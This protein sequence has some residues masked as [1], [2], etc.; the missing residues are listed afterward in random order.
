MTDNIIRFIQHGKIRELN[1]QKEQ[2]P[3]TTT[4]LNFLRQSPLH[5]GTKEGCAEGDCGA[6]TVV[7]T[8]TD[9]TGRLSYTAIDSCLVFLPMLHGK[10]LLTIEDL[11]KN[12]AGSDEL[13]PLQQ[14]MVDC[15]GTQ[16][17]YCTPGFAMSLLALQKQPVTPTRTVIEDALT[18]NLCRCTG[19]RS[20][21]DAAAL[22]CTEKK[23]KDDF[24]EQEEL[25]LLQ[26]ATLRQS[27]ADLSIAVGEQRY[28]RPVSLNQALTI[29]KNESDCMVFSGATD[30]ALRVTKRHEKLH[31]LLDL[32]GIDELRTIENDG[33]SVRIGACT[34]LENLRNNLRQ[35]YP[36]LCE[37]LDVFGSR[38]IRS[39]AT[40]GGNIGSASPIGDTLPVLFA[41]DARIELQNTAGKRE[42]PIKE[43]ITG[44]RQTALQPDELITA[45]ILPETNTKEIVRSYKVSKR[46]DLDISTVSGGF[47]LLL[48][49]D[50]VVAITLAFGGM[51]AKTECATSAEA[52]L[53]GKKW[54]R[55]TI[56]A[57]AALIRSQF[58]P[59]SDA[60]S[61]AEFRSL[62]A[63]NLLLKFWTETTAKS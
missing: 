35:Q 38:Q 45:V 19:Y 48:E 31:K 18:G 43:F 37:M 1:L 9:P 50:T 3:P 13:H 47:R 8:E 56:E 52:F 28:Y 17:G 5:R 15:N 44:Y 54:K 26:L 22:A 63:G 6:C 53:I 33:K 27:T 51:A 16:C 60:R 40:L 25:T 32:G 61:G 46:K 49:N 12:S 39:L 42:L 29:K 34:T 21:L 14:A 10:Q 24:D 55:E 2:L 59:L 62:A 7:I 41:Y 58:K 4:V 36:A 20:I 30:L 57:A 11:R 23:Q